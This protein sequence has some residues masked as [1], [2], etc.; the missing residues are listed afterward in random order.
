MSR[1]RIALITALVAALGA[2]A[3]IVAQMPPVA[4]MKG[5]VG[6]GLLLRQLKTTAVLMQAVAH[7]DDENN[8]MLAATGWGQGVRTVVVSATRGDGGQNEIGPELFD[9]LATA[10]TE[11]LLSVHQFDSAEQYFTRAVDFGYSFSVDET[12]EKW[13][14]QEILGDYVRLIRTIRPD[15]VIAMRPDGQGG[16]QHHQASAVISREAYL[17]AGD[18]AKFPEQIRE[19]LRPWQPKKFY[20]TGRFGF[21]GEPP[22][23]SGAKLTAVDTGGYD[24]LLGESYA[25]I[26]SRA[27]SH[28]KT[29][30]MAQLLSLPGPSSAGYQLVESAI[31]GLKEKGDASLFDGIDTSVP[32]LA[33]YVPGEA[34]AALT[35]GLAAI[36]AA[37]AMADERAASG[38]P[39][40]AV[41]PLVGGLQAV[42]ALRAQLASAALKI[43]DD[44]RFEID[45]RLERK[46]R[47]FVDAVLAAGGIRLEALADD[48]LVV[49]GQPVKLTVIAANRGASAIA[50]KQIGFRGFDG[51]AG[52][53]KTGTVAAAGVYR[54]EAAL[55]ISKQARLTGQYWKRLPDAARYVFEPD[56][57]FGVPFRP[58][59]FRVQFDLEIGGA[60]IPVE[61]DV[62]YRY[63]GN[64]FSGEKR[65][66]LHVVPRLAVSVTPD[67]AILPAVRGTAAGRAAGRELR[68]TVINGNKGPIDG[69][70]T[71]EVPAGWTVAAAVREGVARAPGRGRDGALHG[72]A[73]ARHEAGLVQHQGR[74]RRRGR[75]LH[76]RLPG[77]GVSAHAAAPPRPCRRSP[78]SRSSTWPSPRASM[79]AT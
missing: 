60:A 69:E 13:G 49:P 61:R 29:Q 36:A 51:E 20:Y 39:A 17:A 2:S 73:A 16:G 35:S 7:P 14:R 33:R 21:A 6:L 32:G 24:P 78:R 4:G 1:S 34:P 59:P 54:C 68:V 76:G 23:P 63:E 31:P 15:I 65:M 27:R 53:C 10:R 70:V 5:E 71:L 18:P 77:G 46:E 11:E 50:V 43:P 41:V 79:S 67:I 28:H 44:A 37:T 58:T 25:E 47:Q 19:G 57:P 30:G 72:D 8:G 12:Y 48:G 64:I 55:E 3:A 22:P 42:R 45:T 66:E 40:A 26:G 75:P 74:R 38:G 62:Q 56:A 9:A 52:V